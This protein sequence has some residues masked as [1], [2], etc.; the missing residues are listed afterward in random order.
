MLNLQLKFGILN[1][2]LYICSVQIN[3]NLNFTAME[4]QNFNADVLI[5]QIETI[6]D[7][8][9]PKLAYRKVWKRV[10]MGDTSIGIE[11]AANII[12]INNLSGQ[13]PQIVS[14]LLHDDFDLNTQVFG[15]NGGGFIYRN[16]N[17]E[18]P[19][20]K[21]LAMKGVKIPFRKPKKEQKFVFNAIEKFAQNWVKAL[22]DNFDA[23]R[24]KDIVDY[25]KLFN[26]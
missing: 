2:K 9:L 6:L 19:K 18:D 14:L 5:P 12:N 4:N 8:N 13:K 15:G 17:K 1:L 11:F 25:E 21:Y 20:E 26:S 16:I 23:L 10:C 3:N 24:Y 22:K 7:A